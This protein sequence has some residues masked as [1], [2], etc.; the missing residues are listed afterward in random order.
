[1][2]SIHLMRARPIL[3]AIALIGGGWEAGLPCRGVRLVGR[4]A[5]WGQSPTAS[6]A[7]RLEA[8]VGET[9]DLV[10]IGNGKRF[11]RP[12][13]E[14]VVQRSGRVTALRLRPE[15]EART[16]SVPATGIVK[17][18]AARGTLYEADTSGA[19]PGVRR[20][21][22]HDRQQ[23][24]ASLLRMRARGVAPWPK[25]SAADHAAQVVEL[26]ALVARVRQA[27]P[28]LALTSTH[29]F[30]VASDMP[31]GR[32]APFQ[33]ALDSMHD[34]LCDL[35]GI[36]QGEP[37]WRGKCLVFVFEKQA[38][39][40]AFEGRFM[41]GG[42][43][44]AFGVC[45]QRTDGRVVMACHSSDDATA[46]AHMLVHETSH[47]FNHRWKSPVHLPNWLDEGIAEW[48]GTQVVPTGQQVALKEAKALE[49]MRS[50]GSIGPGFFDDRPSAHIQPVQ[51]GIASGL[52]KLLLTRDR[53]KFA[54]FV[55]GL[56]EGQGVEESLQNTFRASLDDL[57][58][59]YG[60]SLGLPTL[61][62]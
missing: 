9:I 60:K 13:L 6:L 35:Y 14:G 41:E 19:P 37:V 54:A 27:F 55:Q 45:H 1:M 36:P 59:A 39:F 7:E 25:L 23:E 34:S 38:D 4:S 32:L 42:L 20:L 50:T 26:E 29:E 16:V 12:V 8:H 48:V 62:R 24:E 47:G 52:V 17:I 22:Q 18:M 51:Y 11:V 61:S 2:R 3:L 5:A 40:A 30:L 10:E 31:P 44:A 33:A 58:K 56:K 53:K 28:A 43:P 15:G 57:L 49:Y 21:R 46:F